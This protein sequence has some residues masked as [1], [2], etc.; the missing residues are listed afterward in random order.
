MFSLYFL[1]DFV[2]FVFM[3]WTNILIRETHNPGSPPKRRLQRQQD[4]YKMKSEE[5]PLETLPFISQTTLDISKDILQH[6]NSNIQSK[7]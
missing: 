6:N 7:F 2:L 5:R 1:F 4:V 3:A